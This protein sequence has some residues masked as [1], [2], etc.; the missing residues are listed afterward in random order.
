M[1]EKVIIIGC[2]GH[3]RVV[4]DIVKRSGDTVIG[5]LDDFNN[6]DYI[7]GYKVLGIVNDCEKYKNEACF[8]IGIGDNLIRKKIYENHPNI[9]YYTAIDRSAIISESAVIGD[10][11][12][13]MPN[14]VVN[15]SSHI[16]IQ[17]IVNTAAC[18]EHDNILGNFVHISPNC[19]LG[20][21]VSIGDS[22]HI[23]LAGVVKNNIK[24]C[25]NCVIGAGAVVI[26][27]IDDPGVYVG[28]PA[29]KIK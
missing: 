22:T 4:A 23:G 21:T 13:I 15:T 5:F 28:L 10:G 7:N 29:H 20:G 2:G 19:S 3:G 9:K 17:C 24:I 18:I 1:P 27:D 12:C 11:S 25:E 14:A 6:S 8:I 16:G 26:R